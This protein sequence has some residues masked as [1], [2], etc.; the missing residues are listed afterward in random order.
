MKN[1][2]KKAFSLVELSMVILIIG[3]L[4]AGVSR[5]IDLYQDMRLA[6]AR[7]LTQNSRVNRIEDLTMW[8]ESTS[9]QSFEKPNPND[10]DRI[11]LWKNINFKLSNRIDVVQ[12]TQD[13][14]PYYVRNAINGNPALRFDNTQFLT[15]SNVKISEIVSSDQ[16]TVFMVQNNFSG[17]DTTSTF[18]WNNG[19]YRFQSHAQEGG[20]VLIDYGRDSNPNLMRTATPALTDFL[21]Q[22]KIITFVKNGPNVKIKINSAIMAN[23]SNSDNSIDTSLSADFSI[24]RYPPANYSYCFRGYIGEFIVFK[25]A[26]TD[27]EIKDI[28]KYLSKKWS[29][30]I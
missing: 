17:D 12:S 9:E 8:F 5:G 4:I 25:K 22:N 24:G 20:K 6:T 28:E 1:F 2:H 10:G 29:I 30:K 26:L 3:I 16:A 27:A 14:K 13:S 19:N 11:A 21:N 15:A 7:S 18:G 23:S